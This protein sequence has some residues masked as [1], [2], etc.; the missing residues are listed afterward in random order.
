MSD[1]FDCGSPLDC[2]ISFTI[3]RANADVIRAAARERGMT[4]A[5]LIRAALSAALGLTEDTIDC[6]PRVCAV[7]GAPLPASRVCYCSEECKKK[8]RT[9]QAREAR[10]KAASRLRASQSQ[11]PSD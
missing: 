9:A 4:T 5:S 10:I 2:S 11:Y 6:L 1:K 7:C 3:P 8:A